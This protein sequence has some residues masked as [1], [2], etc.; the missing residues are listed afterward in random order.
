M[1]RSR[2]IP[3]LLLQDG[4]LV[5]TV[6]F[7]KGKYIG[8]PINAVKIFNELKADELV[9]L[10]VDATKEGRTISSEVVRRVGEE[11]NMPFSVGGGITSIEDIQKLIACGAEKVILNSFAIKNIDFL[12]EASETF[13]SS[14]IV[15]CID[16]KKTFFRKKHYV[17]IKNGK[18][19]TRYKP[20]ELAKIAEDKGAGEII[21]QSIQK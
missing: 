6:K 20:V 14:T 13:G 3:S 11:A 2:I 5:K 9:L 10:D 17:F 19:V 4:E 7:L 8:D 16:I 15:L 12:K 21:I 18:E 1:L